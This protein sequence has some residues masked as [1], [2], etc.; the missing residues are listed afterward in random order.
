MKKN[1]A[2]IGNPNSGKT[3]LF[4]ALTGGS[5]RVGNWPGVTVEK[6]EGRLKQAKDVTVTDLP[7][8]YSLSP[9]SPEEE[10][11]RK[12]LIEGN[13]GAVINVVDAT[14]LE[15]NLILTLQMLE[16]GLPVIVALNMSDVIAKRGDVLDEKKLSERLGCPVVRVSALKREGIDELA[17]TALEQASSGVW[18]PKKLFRGELSKAVSEISDQLK[19]H[20][21]DDLLY[22]Y[23][24]KMMENDPFVQESVPPSVFEKASE[25]VRR[26]EDS[27]DDDGETIVAAARYEI[28]DS[29]I[30]G[31]YTASRKTEKSISDKIDAVVTHRWL[32]IPIFAAIMFLVYFLSIDSIGGY[33]TDWVNE[34]AFEETILPGVESWLVGLGVEAWLVSLIVDGIL[35][36]V[37]AVLGFL[38]QLLVLFLLL[39]LLEDSGYM[40]RIAFVMDRI[41][42]RFGLS[43]KSFIPI[44]VGAGCAVPGIMATRTIE[45]ERDRKITAMT[46]S[47]M[48]CSAKLPVIALIAGSLFG[49]SGL[50]AVSIY[51]I[52]ILSILVS[53]VVLKK[54]RGVFGKPS[55]FV[56]ELPDYHVPDARNVVLSMGD[57]TWHFVKKAGTIIVVASGLIWFMSSYS[58]SLTPVDAAELSI[59]ASIGNAL[60]PIFAPLGWGDWR[61][62]AGTLTGLV[63]K[64]N[65]IATF[66][67]LFGMEGVNLDTGVEIWDYLATILTPLAGYSFLLFNMLCAPCFAAIGAMRRELGSWKLTSLA[68]V[69]QTLFAYTISFAVYQFGMAVTGQA[70]LWIVPA[71]IMVAFLAY[72]FLRNPK[73]EGDEISAEAV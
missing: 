12:F 4:N 62:I 52:G 21:S 51:F 44:I 50:V 41:L 42:R 26:T 53:G 5:Q 31:I 30:K 13:A 25:T 45:D 19:G 65:I 11:S 55:P 35:A 17:A 28:V 73:H 70:S 37:G 10:I 23:S 40:A 66:G 32:A 69:Y 67:I 2:L 14:N 27:F 3:T 33:M 24:V 9:Y 68:V 71:V 8:V 48:P 43:G 56:M 72:L 29:L 34:V 15:R 63:A 18:A 36:G 20:V 64:E 47:F 1:I 38:P 57:R 61:A 58:W 46:T 16:M 60:S 49:E 39:A 7:G 22:W 59:L 54:I 6:K